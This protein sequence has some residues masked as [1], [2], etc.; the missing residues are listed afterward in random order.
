MAL[1]E[2]N[3]KVVV[4]KLTSVYGIKGWVKVHSYTDPPEKIFTFSPWFLTNTEDETRHTTAVIDGYRAHGKGL[5]AHIKGI[6]D[7]NEAALFCQRLIAVEMGELPKLPEG[8][9]Y[10]QQLTGL[11]VLSNY[12]D[13]APV[14]LG[15]VSGLMETG[16]NDILV[17]APCEGSIDKRERLLPYVD[18]YILKI[19]LAAGSM[20]VDWDP[21]F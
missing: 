21:E 19:D 11:Q 13:Q 2:Q 10:W 5:V 18:A 16:A 6:D 17:V 15:E 12:E 1:S 7:R 4:G 14:L 20:L 9:Y 3:E 8:E